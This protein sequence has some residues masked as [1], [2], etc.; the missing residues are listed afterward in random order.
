M[1][2]ITPYIIA[3]PEERLLHLK[4][5][6]AL[7]DIP[8]DQADCEPWLQG[9][10]S[11]DISRLI[12]YWANKYDWRK[13]EAQLNEIPQ[14]SAEIEV[15]GFGVFD[16]HFVHQQSLR[17]KAIPL[18]FVHGWPGSFIEVTK[19]LHELVKG[20]DEGPAF[21][22]VAPSLIDFGFSG[23]SGKVSKE[24]S[25]MMSSSW[26]SCCHLVLVGLAYDHAERFQHRATRRS[27]S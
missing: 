11:A 19:V 23:S 25:R 24:V 26:T 9:P 1:T 4:Q 3:V 10:P 17:R 8:S 15:T 20:Y 18:L 14:L 12:Q 27:V 2:S 16:V 7:A 13:A 22:V 5:R 21:H 6:L